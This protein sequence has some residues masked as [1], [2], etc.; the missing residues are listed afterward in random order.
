MRRHPY[1]RCAVVSIQ[2][3]RGERRMVSVANLTREDG[4]VFMR[5]ASDVHLDLHTTVYPLAQANRALDDLRRGKLTGA[6][7]LTVRQ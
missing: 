2:P 7:V 5:V 1:E 3:V 6:A 4:R